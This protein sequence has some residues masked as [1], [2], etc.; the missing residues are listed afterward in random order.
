MTLTITA[1]TLLLVLALTGLG[2]RWPL[3]GLGLFIF[4]LPFERIGAYPLNA[5]TGYPLLHPAQI[6]GAALIG[7][8]AL[9]WLAGR[10]R[11]RPIKALPWLLVFLATSLASALLVHVQ[12]VWE[13]WIWLIFITALF[14]TVAQFATRQN[15]AWIRRWLAISTIV[16]SLFGLYQ[17]LGDLFGLPYGATGIRDRYS[18]VVLGFPRL[19]ST[20]LEPLYFANFLFLPLFVFLALLIKKR[21]GDRLSQMALATASVAFI[22]TFS[23]GAYVSGV[24]GVAVLG[25]A[26]GG[27]EV[28]AWL[29]ANYKLVAI[30]LGVLVVGSGLL[31]SFSVA[32]TKAGQNGLVTIENFFGINVLKTGSFTER[33]SDEKLAI[34]IFKEHPVF[35]VGIGGFGS[36][37]YG[38]HIGKCVY[39]PNNQALEVLAEGGVVGFTVFY[40]FLAAL[41]VYGWLA[42]KRTSGDQRTVIAGLLAAV[43]AMV[44]QAQTFSG[45][46]CCLTY[47]WGTL[48]LLAGL[49][50]DGVHK[51]AK[52]G[53]ARS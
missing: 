14:Y 41:V 38:C 10:V 16:V 15:L 46:L 34:K 33:L 3:T 8:L 6:T 40:G 28:W 24:V 21:G 30:G 23:R 31:L 44:V 5:A 12:E 36:A 7:A 35:G 4:S 18:K 25:L 51:T 22:L 45:F 26:L 9:R 53:R 13:I 48:A 27:R 49:S 19:Q 50:N 1:A 32:R 47:T 17:F 42:L 11:L 29:K 2:W 39:R 43:V 52:G 20:A 37:Y